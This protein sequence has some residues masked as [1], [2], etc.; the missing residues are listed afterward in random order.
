MSP[1]RFPACRR[2]AP[3]ARL[4]FA[5]AMLLTFVTG[6]QTAPKSDPAA[7]RS[8]LDAINTQ[9]MDA[10]ARKDGAALGSVYAE[11]ALAMPPGA[12]QVEGRAAI[13]AMW[14]SMLLLPLSTFELK[15]SEVGGGVETAWETGHY[16]LLSTDGS[17]ADAGKYV[18][19]W[20]QVEGGWKIYRDI[21]NSDA[22]SASPAAETPAPPSGK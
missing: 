16:R 14:K 4:A 3:V 21:W 17:V 11:D 15:T 20:K 12:V 10:F 2:Y 9:F 5:A 8:T 13:E 6:C 1:A 7:L 19:I 22:P 18:V